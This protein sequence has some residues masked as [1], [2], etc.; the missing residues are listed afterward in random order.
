MDRQGVADLEIDVDRAG[1]L[2]GA[3]Q[4]RHPAVTQ[5]I[6]IG[7]LLLRRIEIGDLSLLQRRSLG[8]NE[9]RREIAAAGN[10]QPANRRLDDMQADDRIGNGLRGHLDHHRLVSAVMIGLFQ[11]GA[12]MFDVV[13]GAPR[14]HEGIDRLLDFHLRQ[15]SRAI[16][17]IG[18]NVEGRF[19]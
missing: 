14:S 11:R 19:R 6:D 18:F 12:R 8:T 16:D 3:Q 15:D 2:A 7:Q 5:T 13:A 1:R 4:R 9:V 17:I 10:A